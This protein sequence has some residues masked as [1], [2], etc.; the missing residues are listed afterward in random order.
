MK[1][2]LVF[3]VAAALGGSA[4]GWYISASDYIWPQGQFGPYSTHRDLTPAGVDE[5]FAEVRPEAFP[6]VEVVGGSEYDFGVMLRNAEGSHEFELRNVGDAELELEVTGSTC[7]CTL[8]SLE[9]NVLAPGESTRVQMSW[10]AKT[11]GQDFRQSANLRTTD[12]ERGELQLEI[13]GK[14]V[15][16]LDAVPHV[17]NF[18]DAASG[19]AIEVESTVYNRHD[20][21][22]AFVEAHW[23]HPALEELAEVEVVA[24]EVQPN[25]HELAHRARQA[26][27]VTATIRPGLSQGHVNQALRLKFQQADEAERELEEIY[28]SLI[29]RI[30]GPIS[31]LGGPRLTGRDG[32][33]Y[34]FEM[35]PAAVGEGQK[36][37]V[38]VVVRGE[39]HSAVGLTIKGVTPE[40]A[41]SASLGDPVRQGTFVRYPLELTIK[42]DAPVGERLGKNKDDYGIVTIEPES[43]KNAPLQLRVKYSVGRSPETR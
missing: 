23:A 26:F 36:D 17:W 19:E 9:N 20:H 43:D 3:L 6:R 34:V 2:F 11:S 35:K 4:M 32:G 5:Y 1:T 12:P 16:L 21:D 7:K 38:Y 41:L 31:L 39:Q 33:S 18:G 15:D 29:G 40:N 28:I 30:V 8:G 22:I 10:T 25:E 13:A 14:V 24:R 27:D 42:K 37:K